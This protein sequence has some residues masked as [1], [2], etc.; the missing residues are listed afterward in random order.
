MP[1]AAVALLLSPTDRF[2]IVL[3]PELGTDAS[4]ANLL[5]S[6]ITTLEVQW[7]EGGFMR[8]S[9]LT[10]VP[11]KLD[12]YAS[13]VTSMSTP[14][15]GGLLGSGGSRGFIILTASPP[16][17]LSSS[18]SVFNFELLSANGALRLRFN[19]RIMGSPEPSTPEVGLAVSFV[20]TSTPGG[21][22]LPSM[23]FDVTGIP[24]TYLNTMRLDVSLPP[25]CRLYPQFVAATSASAGASI[26]TISYFNASTE[27]ETF[28]VQSFNVYLA[29]LSPGTT[30]DFRV[31]AVLCAAA[32]PAQ[33][34]PVSVSFYTG[35]TM[36]GS[37]TA[38]YTPLLT[39]VTYVSTDLLS[40]DLSGIYLQSVFD[41]SHKLRDAP[42]YS[43]PGPSVSDLY[44]VAF[45]MTPELGLVRGSSLSL[46][47][48]PY[49]CTPTT[50]VSL[51]RP[52][53]TSIS[54]FVSA[55][56]AGG[57]AIT[58]A[59]SAGFVL[60][61]ETLSVLV[62]NV[63]VVAS[64][65]L[66]V[67]S[68]VRLP[69]GPDLGRFQSSVADAFPLPTNWCNMFA[70][71]SAMIHPT[72][73]GA[74]F[75]LALRVTAEFTTSRDMVFGQAGASIAVHFLSI[76][77]TGWHPAALPKL[78]GDTT[79][80]CTGGNAF[81]FLINRNDVQFGRVSDPSGGS[82]LML[83]A[84]LALAPGSV[85]AAG[86]QCSFSTAYIHAA[87]A[88]RNALV[89]PGSM[90][91]IV[92][93]IDPRVLDCGAPSLADIATITLLGGEDLAVKNDFRFE[94]LQSLPGLPNLSFLAADNPLGVVGPVAFVEDNYVA[95]PGFSGLG[96][97]IGMAFSFR[98]AAPVW[99]T[100]SMMI[101]MTMPRGTSAQSATATI[102]SPTGAPVLFGTPV[103][104]ACP[105]F[106][107]AQLLAYQ[108]SSLAVG[109]EVG[110]VQSTV[111]STCLQLTIG[112]SA[113]SL[114][115]GTVYTMVLRSI[116]RSN[117]PL[118]LSTFPI[119]A[120]RFATSDSSPTSMIA[121]TASQPVST[122]RIIP[123]RLYVGAP[124][125]PVDADVG[126]VILPVL[127]N[128]LR[129][130]AGLAA[131]A[132]Q[133][134]DLSIT[135]VQ[136]TT[137]TEFAVTRVR[138]GAMSAIPLTGFDLPGT[139]LAALALTP[140][141]QL[142]I[143][144]VGN[145]RIQ[146]ISFSSAITVS[147]GGSAQSLAF[148]RQGQT[149]A[150]PVPT[151][152]RY[153]RTHAPLV[154][155]WHRRSLVPGSAGSIV[156]VPVGGAL[157]MYSLLS[158]GA[159]VFFDTQ[160]PF[161]VGG[162]I[163]A[164]ASLPHAL[165][166][167]VCGRKAPAVS[168]GAFC[169]LV[170]QESSALSVTEFAVDASVDAWVTAVDLCIP[171][172]S[173]PTPTACFF[174]AVTI[175]SIPK[176][177][178]V[179]RNFVYRVDAHSRAVTVS[180]AVPDP[181]IADLKVTPFEHQIVAYRY[182]DADQKAHITLFSRVDSLGHYE[183]YV[184]ETLSVRLPNQP[185]AS[186]SPTRMLPRIL[187]TPSREVFIFPFSNVNKWRTLQTLPVLN[188]VRG[189]LLGSTLQFD[190]VAPPATTEAYTLSFPVSTITI[191]TL[192][193]SGN[194]NIIPASA[195]QNL[196]STR[197][198]VTI[199]NVNVA[200]TLKIIDRF[201]PYASALGY[202]P[203]PTI[204]SAVPRVTSA[205]FVFRLSVP[206][207]S[208]DTFM[209][210]AD[211][212]LA[213][214][215]NSDSPTL[216]SVEFLEPPTLSDTVRTRWVFCNPGAAFDWSEQWQFFFPHATI[217]PGEYTVRDLASTWSGSFTCNANGAQL[218]CQP[219]A[220]PPMVPVRA[221]VLT[222]DF[223][224]R[225]A[226][227]DEFVSI[228]DAQPYA[229]R[230]S[231]T[232]YGSTVIPSPAIRPSGFFGWT[233][234]AQLGPVP[235]A[236]P[237]LPSWFGSKRFVCF[238][239]GTDNHNCF[240]AEPTGSAI[241]G[242]LT[243]GRVS[244]A[245]ATSRQ[246]SVFTAQGTMVDLRLDS[247]NRA[248]AMRFSAPDFSAAAETPHTVPNAHYTT[249]TF[250]RDLFAARSPAGVGMYSV[251]SAEIT[252]AIII[253]YSL[254]FE[255]LMLAR[256]NPRTTRASGAF[257]V[258]TRELIKYSKSPIYFGPPVPQ[259]TTLAAVLDWTASEPLTSNDMPSTRVIFIFKNGFMRW[260][261]LSIREKFAGVDRSQN[262]I[263]VD[264]AAF[265]CDPMSGGRSEWIT[266]SSGR[267]VSPMSAV[268]NPGTGTIYI[269]TRESSVVVY[270]IYVD[271][272][273]AI[274][275]ASHPVVTART[276]CPVL[277][278]ALHPSQRTLAYGCDDNHIVSL[279]IM[280][281]DDIS[282]TLV[283]PPPAVGDLWHIPR[284]ASPM[285]S[286]IVSADSSRTA[287]AMHKLDC[288]ATVSIQFAFGG[289]SLV[290]ICAFSLAAGADF[291][292]V[293]EEVPTLARSRSPDSQAAISSWSFT[294][295]SNL[296]KIQ[297]ALKPQC[298]IVAPRTT[299]FATA[300]PMTI[301]GIAA[302]ADAID[303]ASYSYTAS[304][305]TLSPPS[306]TILISLDGVRNPQSD[307]SR[308]YQPTLVCG[309]E[310]PTLQKPGDA[311]WGLSFSPDIPNPANDPYP[312]AL[313]SIP[314]RSMSGGADSVAL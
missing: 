128:N 83:Q 245:S 176:G 114:A 210:V 103:A 180:A 165:S 181:P 101:Q 115:P 21:Q 294:T 253:T 126:S 3:P 45:S 18:G 42:A 198:R 182:A 20:T 175:D 86:T 131:G 157:H 226:S 211:V 64:F 108:H 194:T 19:S 256:V 117:D 52:N 59:S 106:A 190:F 66:S 174:A 269:G 283:S 160:L 206:F 201:S 290:A 284:D 233:H 238:T 220:S 28:A 154:V 196:T 56:P 199:N 244:A 285:V 98:V 55:C 169:S 268:I 47:F 242:G 110:K 159:L 234:R 259:A 281:D 209:S 24:G 48:S 186:S 92:T 148:P 278:I 87:P 113:A 136:S 13:V 179:A 150:D 85:T 236:Y 214:T 93:R 1:D 71:A 241:R 146:S 250:D 191:P 187:T 185:G 216:M 118:S 62:S 130:F 225:M 81:S 273:G 254:S 90:I 307:V 195:I 97:I 249:L 152:T 262:D 121:L 141:D 63:A 119:F 7:I 177:S 248:Y 298:T 26:S 5:N 172:S 120:A 192:S 289:T 25:Q 212:Q 296:V 308:E 155:G 27:A 112:S 11:G 235:G 170:R 240:T 304:L 231:H 313:R 17:R 228:I 309:F 50:V 218:L 145:T 189:S 125:S 310:P 223:N 277:L 33:N 158:S 135:S 275:V 29:N 221:G 230:L 274:A 77:T 302:T 207:Q 311:V 261:S 213:E 75:S 80:T 188:N 111:E 31:P 67:Q 124:L 237:H 127:C 306:S 286:G 143:A 40:V 79:L 178:P 44:G 37:A 36:Y 139:S 94:P 9:G 197:R 161:G 183:A 142:L 173:R 138:T 53:G 32:S 105:L 239:L 54:G 202:V 39:Y 74:S 267:R 246:P 162:E 272:S 34:V 168:R 255:I 222:V 38:S 166:I 147:S 229:T 51:K 144:N 167:V 8:T 49:L 46:E 208:E 204:N 314:E 104:V 258:L 282:R 288:L 129:C 122:S 116:T 266:D 200:S 171:I 303:L 72:L 215:P 252:G 78:R 184:M 257:N 149:S 264:D 14:L 291:I 292:R 6:S 12:K 109:L 287:Y 293:A 251:N 43:A 151:T 16:L 68:H 224:M 134:A 219:P 156:Y 91:Q 279:R 270:R 102:Y 107:K 76:N 265:S 89:A 305:N 203:S 4:W 271:A 263:D 84:S 301:D 30:Q 57:S 41:D 300:G 247:L 227:A 96:D 61:G 132:I 133:T 73:L 95:D 299:S 312:E 163:T 100:A 153:H 276:L 35:A 99:A 65:A 243:A 205:P 23:R 60:P 280:Y 140:D 69:Y 10:A 123:T 193:A 295:R 22:T 88:L 70:A 164:A 137:P 217:I 260:C 58:L 15:I 232:P 297:E 82:Q 2:R